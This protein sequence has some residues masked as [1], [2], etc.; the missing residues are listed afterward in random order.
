[1]SLREAES[2]ARK[3]GCQI[4]IPHAS[5]ELLFRHEE[6][7]TRLRLNRRRKDLE[8]R[9]IVWL[10]SL[11]KKAD[12]RPPYFS[13]AERNGRKQLWSVRKLSSTTPQPFPE[14]LRYGSTCTQEFS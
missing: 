10:R 7:I 12:G 11:R 9:G 3:L 2:V 6:M 1:M 14:S 8:R 13:S 4:E 5:G